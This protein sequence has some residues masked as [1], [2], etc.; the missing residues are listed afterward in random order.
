MTAPVLTS[1]PVSG[2]TRLYA[3]LGNPVA[4]V[5]SP[6]V[7][8]ARFRA[9]GIDALLFAAQASAQSLR[10]VV[11]GLKAMDNVHGLLVT[12]PHKISMLQHADVLLPS[13][14]RVGA[15]N[16]LRRETDGTWTADMFDGQGFLTAL[17]AKGL[18]VEGKTIRLYGAG[19]AG[20]AIAV[21]LADAGARRIGLIDPDRQKA[22]DIAHQLQQACPDCY[23]EAD[24]DSV[25]PVQVIINAS[26]VGMYAGDGLPGPMG[27]LDPSVIVGD[28]IIGAEPTPLLRYAQRSGC[29]TVDGIEMHSGQMQ[30]L[31]SFF[32]YQAIPDR[33]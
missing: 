7:M 5:R 13:A 15:I 32:G 28:V 24:V 1:A 11:T 19:G 30:A 23:I 31:M 20:M 9:A 33:L 22:T 18:S 25:A 8:N 3:M 29:A 6:T 26:P 27:D 14:R 16:A 17:L 12:I 10:A 21:A 2:R 4:Q